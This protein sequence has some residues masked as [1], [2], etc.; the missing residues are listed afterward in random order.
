MNTE[1]RKE[2]SVIVTECVAILAI[3]LCM[4][5]V[6][7]RAGHGDYAASLVP[8][9][10]V[11]A[12]HLVATPLIHLFASAFTALP[13]QMLLAFADIAALGIACVCVVFLSA[14][15]KSRKNK[16]VYMVLISGYNILLTCAFVAQTLSPLF[17]KIK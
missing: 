16:R 10:I 3:T 9:L 13:H 11:P 14:K 6:F 15:I 12:A 8:I 5:V 7:V 2:L 17:P 1:V 4:V